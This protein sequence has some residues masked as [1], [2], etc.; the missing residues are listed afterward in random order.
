MDGLAFLVGL[1]ALAALWDA[2]RPLW[3]ALWFARHGVLDGPG[4]VVGAA[5]LWVGGMLALAAGTLDRVPPS[6]P[7]RPVLFVWTGLVFALV[8][9]IV[10]ARRHEV[11]E[12]V[13]E[14]L[15]RALDAR[16]VALGALAAVVVLVL[17][18]YVGHS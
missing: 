7:G 15:R 6:L 2:V 18:G 10:V 8:L 1:F 4:L 5:E 12:Q 16:F 17:M 9:A 14:E 3:R 13:P 11:E